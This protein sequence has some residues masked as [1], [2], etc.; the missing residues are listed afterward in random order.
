MKEKSSLGKVLSTR[1]RL[2]KHRDNPACASCHKLMDPV[3]FAVENYDAIGRWRTVEG[4][5][6][7]DASGKL[8]DGTKFD[9][10][11]ELENALLGRPELFCQ[12][13]R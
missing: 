13:S 5:V 1:E 8:F 7:V 11:A 12:H 6:P 2:A 4:G 9:G 10:V 3:G